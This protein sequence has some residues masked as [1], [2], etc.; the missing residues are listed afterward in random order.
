M[1]MPAYS[2]GGAV[3]DEKSSMLIVLKPGSFERSITAR[4]MPPVSRKRM[5]LPFSEP[6][7]N[8]MGMLMHC[9]SNKAGRSKILND[10]TAVKL[11]RVFCVNYSDL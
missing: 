5:F 8:W 11:C 4:I 9:S 6:N 10:N 1:I 2:T 7:F 3:R